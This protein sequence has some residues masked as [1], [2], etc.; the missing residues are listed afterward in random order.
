MSQEKPDE[1]TVALSR[2]IACA[3]ISHQLGIGYPHCWK[4]YFA[5]GQ[6][7]VGKLWLMLAQFAEA[8]MIESQEDRMR[9]LE[10]IRRRLDTSMEGMKQ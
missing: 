2:K 8:G 10:T 3:V 5:S 7:P 9:A 4:T 6:K 1:A